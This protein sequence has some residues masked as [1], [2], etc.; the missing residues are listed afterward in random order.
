MSQHLEGTT[1][2][3]WAEMMA[4]TAETKTM[5]MM[6]TSTT[7]ILGTDTRKLPQKLAPL[8]ERRGYGVRSS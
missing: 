6:M 3:L 7:K 4:M 5:M 1:G 8:G 2:E